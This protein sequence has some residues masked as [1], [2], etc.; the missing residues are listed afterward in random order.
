MITFDLP[1]ARFTYRVAAVVVYEGRVLLNREE[2]DSFWF[3]PG[4]RC[5]AMEP[6]SVALLREMREEL[7][8]TVTIERLLWVAENFFTDARGPH[9]ELGLYY[10][11]TL[12]PSSPLLGGTTFRGL[13]Q[14]IPLVLQWFP[15]DETA[16][17]PLY[18]VFL[19]AGLQNLPD[20]LEHIVN[21][22]GREPL[23]PAAP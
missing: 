20:R 23:D 17:L 9:H 11:A 7:G 14:H 5:E 2:A 16:H 1:A 18:P 19:R 6:S 3:L 21:R 13:E 22:D 8:E 10:L 4:G 12:P 15:L